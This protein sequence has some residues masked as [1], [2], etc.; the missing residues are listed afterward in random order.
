MQS[1]NAFRLFLVVTALV[2]TASVGISAQQSETQTLTGVVSDASCGPSHFIKNIGPAECTRACVGHKKD[3][4]LVVG[5]DTYTLKGH[6]GEVD[7][8]AG[9][10]VTVE[11]AVNGKTIN[12][13]S[14]TPKKA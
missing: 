7:K 14:V 1:R 3:Y 4:A 9:K 2:F 8:F 6:G 5:S 13:K 10:T 11:G 12:V